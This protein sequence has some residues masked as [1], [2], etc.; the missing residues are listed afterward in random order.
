MEYRLLG[1]TG[2]RVGAVGLGTEYLQGLPADA[3][4]RVVHAALDLPQDI[5][6]QGLEQCLA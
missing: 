5:L 4:A 1:R 6:T 3:V 2:T